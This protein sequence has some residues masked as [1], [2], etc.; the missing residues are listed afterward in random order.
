M[1]L[2]VQAKVEK[3]W[4]LEICKYQLFSILHVINFLIVNYFKSNIN[5][6]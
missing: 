4:N 1:L 5:T 6:V 2:I 3:I